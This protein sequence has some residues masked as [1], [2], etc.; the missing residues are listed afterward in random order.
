MNTTNKLNPVLCKCAEACYQQELEAAKRCIDECFDPNG[1][2]VD[3][4]GMK[5]PPYIKLKRIIDKIA[6]CATVADCIHWE[7]FKD[8]YYYVCVNDKEDIRYVIRD[9]DDYACR[10]V[11]RAL[12]DE[13]SVV[14]HA[15]LFLEKAVYALETAMGID[16]PVGVSIIAYY[17]DQHVH[18]LRLLKTKISADKGLWAKFRLARINAEKVICNIRY[19]EDFYEQYEAGMIT[20][21]F[22]DYAERYKYTVDSAFNA[23]VLR[24]KASS[25]FPPFRRYVAMMYRLFIRFMYDCS[26]LD[27]GCYDPGEYEE[28]GLDFN[29]VYAGVIYAMEIAVNCHAEVIAMVLSEM[30]DSVDVRTCLKVNAYNFDPILHNRYH[31]I[32]NRAKIGL[33]SGNVG[34]EFDRLYLD[35]IAEKVKLMRKWMAEAPEM[36]QYYMDH[37]KALIPVYWSLDDSEYYNNVHYA[38]MFC[39]KGSESYKMLSAF[40]KQVHYYR[41]KEPEFNTDWTE[42]K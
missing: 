17:I 9:N 37:T 4:W 36:A 33:Q 41:N 18:K 16:C 27:G 32:L 13:A 34:S 24:T 40:G 31:D 21:T 20:C 15:N 23:E 29:V 8:A 5:I 28:I 42:A 30:W 1:F 2:N 19:R 25:K 38:T 10:D 6:N 11:Y 22:D 3:E 12:L 26:M 14:Y 7:C 35:E 39:P